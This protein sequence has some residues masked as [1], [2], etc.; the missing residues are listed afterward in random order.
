MHMAAPTKSIAWAAFRRSWRDG[1]WYGFDS[2]GRHDRRPGN[3]YVAEA[4]RQLFGAWESIYLLAPP[5]RWSSQTNRLTPNFALPIFSARRN[6]ADIAPAILLTNSEPLAREVIAEV[7]RQL[8]VLPTADVAAVA[9][10]NFGQVIV[11]DSYDEMVRAADEIAS[12]HVQIMTKTP[13]YFLDNMHN[14][15]ALFL[16]R[17]R[18]SPS[19]TK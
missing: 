11:C 13:Q 19:V 1:T 3:A 15:G 10:K 6:M 14:Y 16:V 18:M 8:R 4:K 17:R 5:K 2:G 12:E 7:E 9:W